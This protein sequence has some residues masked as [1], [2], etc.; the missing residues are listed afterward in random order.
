[1][2]THHCFCGHAIEVTLRPGQCFGVVS[3]GF[4]FSEF[5]IKMTSSFPQPVASI[6]VVIPPH[7]R[8]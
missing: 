2:R 3:V 6:G 5:F 7:T 8:P 4:I 1:M